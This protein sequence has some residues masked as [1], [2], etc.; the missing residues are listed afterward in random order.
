[1]FIVC[2]GTVV[3]DVVTACVS[4]SG[5]LYVPG[6]DMTWSLALTREVWHLATQC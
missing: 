2:G 5:V 1:M 4:A 3:I 6:G